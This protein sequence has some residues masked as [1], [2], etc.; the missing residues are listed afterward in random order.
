MKKSLLLIPLSLLAMGALVGCTNTKQPSQDEDEDVVIPD[1]SGNTDEGDTHDIDVDVVDTPD[2]PEVNNTGSF[3]LKDADGVAVEA[4]S[5]VYTISAAGTF[6]AKGVLEDGQILVNAGDEDE[7]EIELNGATISCSTDS[8]IKVLNADKVEISAKKKTVNAVI[9]NRSEK[10]VDNE[11]LGEGAITSHCD[12]KLKGAGTLTVTGNYNNGIHS[13]DDLDIQKETLYVTAVNNALKGKD[14]I[15]MVSGTVTAISKKGNGLK[16][17]NTDISSKGNQRGSITVEGGTLVVDSVYD[18][19]DAAYNVVINEETKG[20][21]D[22]TPLG[23]LV[24]IKTG[25]NATYA[26]NYS[27]ANSAKGLK[28][29][30]EVNISAGKVAIQAVD[31]AI[32]AN[33]GGSL[34]NGET[35]LGNINV[36]GG[37]IR[38]LSGDDGLHADNTLTVSGGRIN[39]TGAKESLEATHV[40]I[41]GGSTSIYGTDD[42]VN[43]SRKIDTETPSVLIS[44][45]FLDVAV[46]RGDTDGIDSNGTFT[47]TGG[48]VVSRGSYGNAQ[49]MS[50]G[51]DCDKTAV[52]SGGTFIAFNGM[53]KKLNTGNG[54]LYAYYGSSSSWGPGGGGGPGGGVPRPV[55]NASSYK[56]P[57]GTY[58]LSGGEFSKT[59]ENAYDYSTFLIYSSEMSQGTIYSLKLGETEVL[60]WTQNSASQ[61]IS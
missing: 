20:D 50:T 42:G 57:A 39:I 25:T 3:S 54:I 46:S 19:L 30:N 44:G 33:Y 36:S 43:A 61:Q 26:T 40:E 29:D 59:F 27:S 32:H 2:S 8:P 4:V 51:L 58:T 45:G 9:D 15:T 13:T 49:G 47:M 6:T 14:T 12:L 34:Q 1:P 31:D 60:S 23:T 17:D 53:E 24:S 56:F 16:T 52:M 35:G 7:V 37:A 41:K 38:V 5:G 11:A 21:D 28:A 48:F 18:A 10:T 22:V 55:I